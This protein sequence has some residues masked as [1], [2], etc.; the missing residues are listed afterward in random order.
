MKRR[1]RN[2]DVPTPVLVIASVA[3]GG[4]LAWWWLS[5]S[6]A[7]ALPAPQTFTA[8]IGGGIPSDPALAAA[9][10]QLA[11]RAPLVA[12]DAQGRCPDGSVAEWGEGRGGVRMCRPGAVLAGG[13]TPEAEQAA[14]LERIRSGGSRETLA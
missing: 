7:P 13:R 2:P 6:S 11:A 8:P 9:L 5:R 10:A 12:P 4:A 3:A 1:T 14:A